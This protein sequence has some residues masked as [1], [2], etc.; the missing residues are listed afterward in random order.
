MENLTT[1]TTAGDTTPMYIEM[2]NQH[3]HVLKLVNF[4][5]PQMCPRSGKVELIYLKKKEKVDPNNSFKC[6][7]DQRT[8]ITYGIPIGTDYRTGEV[9]F[10]RITL[11]DFRIYDLSNP[12]D[13]KEWACVR[14]CHFVE[15]SPNQFGKPLYRILDHEQEAQN[16]LID[17]EYTERAIALAKKIIGNEIREFAMILEIPGIENDTDAIVKGKVYDKALKSPK[18]FCQKYDDANRPTLTVLK[19]CLSTGLIDFDPMKGYSTKQG[20]Y[21]GDNEYSAINYLTKNNALLMTLNAESKQRDRY[22]KETGENGADILPTAHVEDTPEQKRIKELEKQ[23]EQSNKLTAELNARF[24]QFMEM[25]KAANS[26]DKKVEPE[27]NL[28]EEDAIRNQAKSLNIPYWH[29]KK[30][31]NLMAEIDEKVNQLSKAE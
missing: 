20:L 7:T 29:N 24:T 30:I 28:S 16:K 17:V 9:N 1:V 21:L 31:E 18:W 25:Q 22:Y 5:N 8:G 19:R 14:M 2:K 11:R 6:F 10:Q 3:G 23:L 26:V 15:G 12:Q 13:A 4:E 27:V